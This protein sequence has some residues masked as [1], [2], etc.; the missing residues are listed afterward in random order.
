MLKC[1]HIYCPF[2]LILPVESTSRRSRINF[3][4]MTAGE[5]DLDAYSASLDP[6]ELPPGTHTHTHTHTQCHRLW[7]SHV[8]HLLDSDILSTLHI[9]LNSGLFC[10]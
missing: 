6:Q 5:P 8:Q 7:G 9:L 4:I 3:Q 2:S 1:T 10:V